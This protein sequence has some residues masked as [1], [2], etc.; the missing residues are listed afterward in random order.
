MNK[1]LE[2]FG[3]ALDFGRNIR[4]PSV[5]ITPNL[6]AK[7]YGALDSYEAQVMRDRNSL[8]LDVYN[9]I[10]KIKSKNVIK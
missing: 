2:G 10:Q 6:Y 5:K 3:V 1:I 7:K 9:S 4:M 8:E